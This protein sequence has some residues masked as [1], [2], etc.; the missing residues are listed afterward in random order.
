MRSLLWMAGLADVW[1]ELHPT[2]R[3]FTFYSNPHDSFCSRID[4][5]FMH[6][7]QL[8]LVR[9]ITIPS[10][11]WSDHDPLVLLL[12]LFGLERRPFHWRINDSLLTT[13]TTYQQ[14]EFFLRTYFTENS[15]SVSSAVPLWEAH[16]ATVRGHVIQLAAV[17]KR[18]WEHR[19]LELHSLLASADA[20]WKSSPSAAHKR[21]RDALAAELDLLASWEAERAL[22]WTKHKFYSCANKPGPMLTRKLNSV[23]KPYKPIRL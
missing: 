11:P 10:S 21:S 12:A 2:E 23:G 19:L 22:R 8:P 15:G 20:R 9:R 13:L 18:E 6:A 4:H 16:K 5:I 3:D 14:I 1:R 17:R 7:Q